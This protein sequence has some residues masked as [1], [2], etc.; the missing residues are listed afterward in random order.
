MSNTSLANVDFDSKLIAQHD[1]SGPRYTSYPTADRFIEGN[2]ASIYLE[3]IKS[4]QV[5]RPAEDKTGIVVAAL[6]VSPDAKVL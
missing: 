4:R 1:C 5:E 3:A 2:I 6:P